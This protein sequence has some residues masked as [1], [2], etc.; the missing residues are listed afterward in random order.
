MYGPTAYYLATQ[1]ATVVMF[2]LYP[3]VVT[4]TAFYF[5]ELD[6]N[7]FGSMLDWMLIL[8]LTAFA[9]GF[10]GFTLGTFMK[11][12]VTATQL[13]M[14]CLIAYCFGAGFYANTGAG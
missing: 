7:T 11:N 8:S 6:E 4:L 5:F 9:G 14:L 3:I 1:T 12:E 10:W 13:N 2:I